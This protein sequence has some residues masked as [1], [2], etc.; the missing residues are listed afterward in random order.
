MTL[1][2][3]NDLEAGRAPRHDDASKKGNPDIR[4]DLGTPLEHSTEAPE[5]PASSQSSRYVGGLVPPSESGARRLRRPATTSGTDSE[6]SAEKPA[7]SA[8][9]QVADGE[10]A[11]SLRHK[12]FVA[13]TATSGVA[14]QT[15][16]DLAVLYQVVAEVGRGPLTASKARSLTRRTCLRVAQALTIFFGNALRWL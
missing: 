8:V 5:R 16:R 1:D 11:L 4:V 9:R 15:F 12:P 6:I 3:A 7:S 13:F 14:P 2:D 10:N